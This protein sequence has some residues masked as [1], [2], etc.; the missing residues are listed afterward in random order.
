MAEV[1]HFD[2]PFRLKGGSFAE[3]EQ[4]SADDI[5]VCVEAIVRTRPGDRDEAPTFGTTDVAFNQV[6]AQGRPVDTELLV[7]QIEEW[8][9]R[10]RALADQEPDRFD[11]TVRSVRV[12]TVSEE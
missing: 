9:P 10:V 4:D 6:D 11:D 12:G 5:A 2:L 3:V 8:E 7:S 1:P